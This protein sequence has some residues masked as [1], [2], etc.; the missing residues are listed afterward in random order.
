MKLYRSLGL[1][2]CVVSG[3]LLLAA[4]GSGSSTNTAARAASASS[5]STSVAPPTVN[6]GSN[7]KLGQLLVDAQGMTLYHNV[8]EQAGAIVC[9]GTCAAA[10][11]PFLVPPGTAPAAGPGLPGTLATVTR[12]D[13][14][15]QATYNGQPL[16][17]FSGDKAPGDANGQGIGGVWF[18]VSAT[19]AATTLPSTVTTVHRVATQTPTTHAAAPAATVAP[20]TP[21]ATSPPATAPPPT[22]PKTTPT[23]YCAYP[24]CY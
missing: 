21:P 15:L 5:T 1:A 10:W 20:T 18:A 14:G 2:G 22:T 24:P 12:P 6:V 19:S 13:G 4:C 23:T 7:P 11:P 3:A 8:K 16:Y 9:T 17:R